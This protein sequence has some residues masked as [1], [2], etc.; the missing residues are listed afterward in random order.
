M[1]SKAMSSTPLAPIDYRMAPSGFDFFDRDTGGLRPAKRYLF[2]VRQG[3]LRIIGADFNNLEGGR[4][5]LLVD[6]LFHHVE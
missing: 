2:L 5:L 3:S 6:R 4:S 1:A